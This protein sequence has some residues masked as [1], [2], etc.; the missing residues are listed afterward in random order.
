MHR[1]IG[2]AVRAYSAMA[3]AA[4]GAAAQNVSF[5]VQPGSLLK[6]GNFCCSIVA[7]D[8]NGDGKPDLVVG[9]QSGLTLLLNNG[10]AGVTARSIPTIL[11]SEVVAAADFNKDGK[12]DLVITGSDGR[13]YLLFG[14]GD[15]TFRQSVSMS[16][17]VKLVA[18]FNRDGNPDLLFSTGS[19]FYV[20]LGNGDGTFQQPSATQASFATNFFH[21]AVSGDLSPTNRRKSPSGAESRLRASQGHEAN[22]A[23]LESMGL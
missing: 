3:L 23:E 17:F 6:A 19:S 7:G 15:G 13:S 14:N 8:F 12:L 20:R 22:T 11:L 16:D 10:A 21:F 4:F 2:L 18:D 5:V 1:R 9:D